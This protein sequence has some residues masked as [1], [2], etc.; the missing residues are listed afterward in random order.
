MDFFAFFSHPSRFPPGLEHIQSTLG[1]SPERTRWRSKQNL[2]YAFAM[3]HVHRER[4]TVRYYVQLEDDIITVPNFISELR[5]YA[6]AR[7]KFFLAEFSNLGF[8]GRMFHNNNDLAHMA[9]F[10][11]LLYQAQPV[12]WVL[13]HVLS[14]KFCSLGE[15]FKQCQKKRLTNIVLFKRWPP[16]FQHVGKHSS[17]PGKLQNLTEK[18]FGKNEK[19]SVAA[20]EN[21]EA[22]QFH[23]PLHEENV[24]QRLHALYERM[25]PFQVDL[26]MPQEMNWLEIVFTPRPLAQLRALRIFFS[27]KFNASMASPEP[28]P[29]SFSPLLVRISH[30]TDEDE[31]FLGEQPD[32]FLL[33]P[34]QPLR[35][36]RSIRIGFTP[37][38][39]Q[40]EVRALRLTAI[41][42]LS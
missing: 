11:L 14:S 5:Q 27:I 10:I 16:L 42:V 28:S 8:I 36:V 40:K 22:N 18:Q 9:H 30:A 34:R 39:W 6:N 21:P 31:A 35:L 17:L 3:L 38:D 33:I 26:A 15:T 13:S 25:Q 23:G 1:D 4:P 32:H 41:K 37:G 29:S 19:I 7:P 20:S 12:D 2:D 24:E